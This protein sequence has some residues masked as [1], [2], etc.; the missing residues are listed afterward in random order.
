MKNESVY[1]ILILFWP[2]VLHLYLVTSGKMANIQ[3]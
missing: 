3:E 1:S 2:Q